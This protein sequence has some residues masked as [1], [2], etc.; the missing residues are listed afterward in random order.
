MSQLTENP[1]PTALIIDDD[2]VFRITAGEHLKT[3]GFNVLEAEDGLSGLS[4]FRTS[5]ADIVLLDVTLPQ[6]DGFSICRQIRAI[7]HGE[8]VP[9]LMITGNDDTESI[10]RAFQAGASDF[11]S[12]SVNYELLI[13]RIH[14]MLRTQETTRALREREKSLAYAQSIAK[15]GNWE[16]LVQASQFNC[17]E[18][19]NRILGL[20]ADKAFN[21]EV[22]LEAIHPEE[23]DQCQR[24]LNQ[25]LQ[26]TSQCQF[27]CRIVH[28]EHG[29]ILTNHEI[30]VITDSQGELLQVHG[31]LQD[32]SE[33]RLIEDR[34]HKMALFDTLTGLP[35]RNNFYDRLSLSISHARY[36]KSQ[37]A[38]M[39]LDL[40]GFKIINDSLGHSSGDQ[41]LKM[42]GNRLSSVLRDG[43]LAARF[44]GDEFC[45]LLE[46]LENKNDAAN[47]AQRCLDTIGQ[48]I[49]VNNT[50]LYPRISIGIAVY[51]FDGDSCDTLIRSADNAMYA[52]KQ[53]GKHQYRF[54]SAEM[55][56]FTKHYLHLEHDLLDALQNNQ[57]ELNYQ[58]QVSLHN[59]SIIGVE[60][61]VRWHHPKLGILAPDQ[62]IPIMEK[63]GL[64][65][66][67]GKWV[68]QSASRQM[69]E[70]RH[71]QV[72][73]NRVAVNISG[74]H[75]S[76]GNL[77]GSLETIIEETGVKPSELQIEITE[78]VIQTTKE[79][80]KNCA[81]L[82]ELGIKIA[83][84]DFG[85]GYSCLSSLSHLPIDCLK[86]DKIFV[87]NMVDCKNNAAIAETIVS[88]SNTMELS[89]I[90]EGV[91]TQEQIQKLKDIGCELGQGFYFC[92]PASAE[93]IARLVSTD[94]LDH[95]AEELPGIVH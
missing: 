48:S 62:F 23:R 16:W 28:P 25:C 81:K 61:L 58:P 34:I 44:G 93:Q 32:I 51:P 5:Q 22:L 50:R 54:F 7:P 79:S 47:I 67:L 75:F 94:L 37:L 69:V 9:V 1:R 39:F 15:L 59:G 20:A 86:I 6:Q 42:I 38:I 46:D 80:I 55:T 41:L 53:A 43:D 27:E 70:W 36:S 3:A 89:V 19:V 12:K 57:F 64:I 24:V 52:A 17:S 29:E 92:K 71:A 45:I 33:R 78:G 30:K 77:I 85:T 21:I 11:T 83:I 91:E 74:V 87:Q 14:Y 68:L 13:H 90:A 10:H 95:Q 31:T 26:K 84:D 76:S 88:I 82:Q 73:I 8:T 72:P 56:T 4:Q 65:V 60:A 18:Q 2:A 49:S 35:N 63:N 66:S 40:D